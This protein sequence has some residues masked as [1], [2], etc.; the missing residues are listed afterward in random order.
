VIQ[1]IQSVA[2]FDSRVFSDADRRHETEQHAIESLPQGAELTRLEWTADGSF[3]FSG[4][5]RR[6]VWQL[7]VE[8][9]AV[10]P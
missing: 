2:R 8:A 9:E 6:P 5:R 10:R 7:T 4:E 1:T 3:T